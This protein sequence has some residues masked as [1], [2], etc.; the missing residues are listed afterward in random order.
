M[1][2]IPN[3]TGRDMVGCEYWRCSSRRLQAITVTEIGTIIPSLGAGTIQNSEDFRLGIASV[4]I[5]LINILERGI[6]TAL[7]DPTGASVV[8]DEFYQ[9]Y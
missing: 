2:Q 4:D 9:C 8:F 6:Q 5:K 1:S 7:V 3:G